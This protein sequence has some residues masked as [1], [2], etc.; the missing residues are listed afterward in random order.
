MMDDKARE[1]MV[2]KTLDKFPEFS[3]NWT[4]D[5]RIAWFHAFGKIAKHLFSLIKAPKTKYI[6]LFIDDD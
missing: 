1:E 6:G 5:V 4:S 2:K 3:N